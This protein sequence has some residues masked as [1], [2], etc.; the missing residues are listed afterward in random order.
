MGG[1]WLTKS[2]NGIASAP[3][4]R[5]MSAVAL[6]AIAD[7]GAQDEDHAEQHHEVGGVLAGREAAAGR[8]GEAVLRE[9]EDQAEH[10]R[11]RPETDARGD[12]LAAV[13]DAR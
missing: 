6:D 9:V 10:D 12:R 8:G 1:I 13:P 3:F 7:D 2:P 5:P 11:E 4:R